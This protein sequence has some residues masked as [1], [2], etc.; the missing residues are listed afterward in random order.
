M[1]DPARRLEIVRPAV[2][3]DLAGAVLAVSWSNDTWLTGGSVL[4]VCW[5]GDRDRLGREAMLLGSLPA[6]VPHAMGVAA[7]A[8]RDLT[9]MVLRRLPGERLDLAWPAL[10]GREQRD[11]VVGLAAALKAVHR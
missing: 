2:P 10:S 6:A 4:R 11:A 3:I 5:R 9:W 1:T 8:H 7:G